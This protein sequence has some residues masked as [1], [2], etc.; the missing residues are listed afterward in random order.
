MVTTVRRA[1]LAGS[2]AA[3][4]L[5]SAACAGE[6]SSGESPQESP[7][8]TDQGSPTAADG[9]P[10]AGSPDDANGELASITVGDVAG[11]PSAFLTYAV[12]E[13]FCEDEGLD[14]TV[15]VS[16]GGAANIP[17][18][19][20]GEFEIAGSNIVSTL[21][22]RQQGLN[23]QIVA[24]GTST[25]DDPENDYHAIVVPGD[26][27][28]SDP[29]DLSGKAVAVN[30]R[31]NISELGVRFAAEEFGVD[32]D[33]VDYVEIGYPD[34]VPSLSEG[35]IDAALLNEPFRTV[36]LSQGMRAIYAPYVHIEP[37]LAIGSYFSSDQY[38]E[39][40]PEI[41]DAFVSCTDAA[42]TYIAENPDEFR[43]ALAELAGL[44][45]DV[46]AEVYLPRW[47][48]PMDPQA[49]EQLGELT[50]EYGFVPEVPSAEEMVYQP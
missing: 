29:G 48:G 26:S 15:S 13:G 4:L 44:D 43:S 12:D 37:G 21:L 14:V 7:T 20:S 22:A 28:I 18:V 30:T 9:S 49:V 25:G 2:L 19:E 17:G 3:M 50:V 24:A 31:A 8:T 45:P 35:R 10:D 27:D 42:G 39:E 36:A 41:I 6:E 46:A 1:W 23:L 40:N 32:A 11:I 38:I 34:I 5:A 16:P 33:S 47:G